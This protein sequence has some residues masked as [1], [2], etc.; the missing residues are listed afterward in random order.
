MLVLT[1][2]LGES[3]TIGDNI[4]VVVMEIRGNQVRLGIEAPHDT[5]V[6]REEVYRKIL[7]ENQ[8]AAQQSPQDLGSVVSAWKS[9]GKPPRKSDDD[10]GN[11]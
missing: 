9:A 2:R 6:H 7:Q 8:R 5:P 11:Q 1:R 3:I 10:K 4:R